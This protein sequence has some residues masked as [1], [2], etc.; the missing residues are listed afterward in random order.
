MSSQQNLGLWTHSHLSPELPLHLNSCQSML[1]PLQTPNGS[2]KSLRNISP[3]SLTPVPSVNGDEGFS[4][5][6]PVPQVPSVQDLHL[7]YG[8]YNP[9]LMQSMP[10]MQNFQMLCT[11]WRPP[12]SQYQSSTPLHSPAGLGQPQPMM[13]PNATNAP[14]QNMT[15]EVVNTGTTT[16][17]RGQKRKNVPTDSVGTA[18]APSRRRRKTKT[19]AATIVPA[20]AAAIC[21]VG[22]MSAPSSKSGTILPTVSASDVWYFM[23]A[24]DSPEKPEKM[25]ENQPRLMYKPDSPYVAC[26]LC[27]DNEENPQWKVYKV[28]DGM[29][30][31][32]RNHLHKHGQHWKEICA[33]M[34]LK[35][36]DK[37]SGKQIQQAKFTIEMFYHLLLKWIAVDD[38]SFNVV[39]CPEFLKNDL[40]V[41]HNN[42]HFHGTNG[43]F[44]AFRFIEGAHTGA[45]LRQEFLKITDDLETSNKLSQITMDNAFNNNTLMVEIEE[46]KKNPRN[47]V[48]QVVTSTD[49]HHRRL[50][51]V[52]QEGN[53]NGFW[54]G[55]LPDRK[56]TLSTVQL[57]HDC[58]TRWSSTFK[59]VDRVLMLNPAIQSFLLETQNA[60]ISDLS[61]DAKDT[62]VLHNIHQIIEVPHIVQ[63]LLSSEQTPTLSMALPAYKVLNSQWT[64]L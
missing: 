18:P 45:H 15:A 23:W 62:D 53:E 55:K 24:V 60:D 43:T 29:T 32:C 14:L 9:Q 5:N 58:V 12:L 61:M 41:Q 56:T 3:D 20:T 10:L 34:R 25:P 22:P 57:L 6:Y 30:P 11:L 51:A 1:S 36:G 59:M 7:T 27:S 26:R 40:K 52:I 13:Q 64:Q 16:E 8:P 19:G 48:L 28:G 46:L 21:G 54:R 38:Q 50:Q 42:F 33:I 35:N 44:H 17:K 49:P 63:E 31:T 47:P 4:H 2:F 39:E 37:N